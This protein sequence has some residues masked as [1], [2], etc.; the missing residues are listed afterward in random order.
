[1]SKAQT[2]VNQQKKA[3][4]ELNLIVKTQS[5]PQKNIQV[6]KLSQPSSNLESQ[7]LGSTLERTKE[8]K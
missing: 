5:T 8:F 4:N 6:R 7:D 2:I 3:Y 1:M